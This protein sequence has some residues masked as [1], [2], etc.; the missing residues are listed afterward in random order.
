MGG[1]PFPSAV[2]GLEDVTFADF[3]ALVIPQG[4]RHKQE[5]FE[6]IAYVNRQDVMEK[7]CKLHCKNS[8][9]AR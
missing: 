4:A 9:L 8:P 2:P 1:G 3:D 6:F 5:A 7:L